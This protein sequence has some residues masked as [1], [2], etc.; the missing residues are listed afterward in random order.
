MHRFH[1]SPIKPLVLL[2]GSFNP[3]HI[4]HI[5]L[6]LEI[7]EHMPVTRVDLIPSAEPPHKDAQGILPFALRLAM[8]EASVKDMELLRVNPLESARKG[9]SYTWH[10]LQAYRQ[11]NP[12]VPLLFVVGG[13][14]LSALPHWYRGIELPTLANIAMVPRAGNELEFFTQTVKEYWPHAQ[15]SDDAVTATLDGVA[16]AF[17]GSTQLLYMPLPRLDISASAIRQRWLHGKCVRYLM[18]D[19]ALDMLNDAHDVA[20]ACWT[21]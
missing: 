1:A 4:G 17:G 3:I 7:A 10:T 21:L 16:T 15:F 14:D 13:E 5:R 20:R 11:E 12:A 8:L 6:A 19:A 18:P 9:P 2:G